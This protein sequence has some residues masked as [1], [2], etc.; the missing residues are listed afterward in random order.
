MSRGMN[1]AARSFDLLRSLNL[2]K[3]GSKIF[4][5]IETPTHLLGRIP[6]VITIVVGKVEAAFVLIPLPGIATCPSK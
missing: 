4:V 3:C 5:L 2:T 6:K 1:S